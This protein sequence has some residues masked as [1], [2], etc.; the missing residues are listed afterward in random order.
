MSLRYAV[1]IKPISN[2]KNIL[3]PPNTL[4]FTNIRAVGT[5]RRGEKGELKKYYFAC[6]THPTIVL[7]MTYNYFLKI[8]YMNDRLHSIIFIQKHNTKKYIKC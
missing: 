8:R 2:L 1:S 3:L 6:L 4:L 7:L 5:L